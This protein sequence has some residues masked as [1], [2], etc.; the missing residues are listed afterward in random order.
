[1]S[2]HKSQNLSQIFEKKII[3]IT[4]GYFTAEKI[5]TFFDIVKK[6][7]SKF[8][9]DSGAEANLLRIIL[10]MYN[11]RAFLEEC[12]LYPHYIEILVAVSV[13][14]NYL[15]DI[16]VRDPEYFYRVVNPSNLK[17]GLIYQDFDTLICN[18]LNSYKTFNA[19]LNYLRSL[20]RRELLR[21]GLKDILGLEELPG[22]TG[23]LSVLA[24]A[25]AKNLF[26]ICFREILQKYDIKEINNSYCVISLG[27]LGGRELN[28]SS[29]IDILIFFDKNIKVTAN[30]D[31]QDFLS[32]VI[33]LFIESSTSLTGAGY[34]YRVDL[35]LRPDGKNSPL[36]NTFA[37]Y[38]NYYESRGE[39]WERQML[40]KADF[41]TGDEKLYNRFHNYIS[42][43]V[44][45]KNFS[46]SP[47][48][49]IKRMKDTIEKKLNDEE[50]I[51]LNAGGI[52]NIEFSV[53]A[54]QLLNG[55]K[56]PDIQT[57]NTLDA[58]DRLRLKNLFS[59]KESGTLKAAYIFYR[60]IEH[61]LQLMNDTQTHS[62][63]T[64]STQL[65]KLSAFL[66]F[67][68][69]KEFSR[70]L[71]KYRES[72]LRIYHSI[73]GKTGKKEKTPEIDFK[74]KIK[75]EKNILYLREGKGLLGQKQFD[76]KSAGSFL[77]IEKQLNEYLSGSSN[78]DTVVENFAR[79]IRNAKFP[80]IWYTEF[81]DKK[82][83]NSFLKL[84]EFSQKSINLFA[85]D[86]ILREIILGKKVFEKLNRNNT[87][88]LNTKALLF[89]LSV[90]ISLGMITAKKT[91][92]ILGDFVR[93]KIK[94]E[95]DEICKADHGNYLIA[96]LGSFGSAEMTFASDIDLVFITNESS[97]GGSDQ[98]IFQKLL[99]QLQKELKPFDV[100]CR[101]RPEG[102]SSQLAWNISAYEN[103]IAT[104]ART[105]EFQSFCKL[106][107]ITGNKILYNR[108]RK[109]ISSRVK[110]LD[111]LRLKTDIFEMRKKLYPTDLSG[112]VERF[113]IKKS[114]GG[115]AD[116]EFTLQYLL[117]TN[118]ASFSKFKKANNES[119]IKFLSKDLQIPLNSRVILEDFYFLKYLSFA[120]QV[121][122][123][124]N[125]SAIMFDE[126]K[127]A[128]I[129]EFLGLKDRREFH[130]KLKEVTGRNHKL[131]EKYISGNTK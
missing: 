129:S 111:R 25:I 95:F 53:Q 63:P 75:S 33:L 72:V 96:A 86:K 131:M 26:E 47:L 68:S 83:F 102:R 73:V 109:S 8:Y 79:I 124:S 128:R 41:V 32:E 44:Y 50:N 85:E 59:E 43:F 90:Q 92:G 110:E 27:K 18:D 112:L 11:K 84:C 123:D 2:P 38:T 6:E 77:K 94:D 108:L 120:S 78:P 12:I 71:I 51:K 46:V 103:Y 115:L 62:V 88:T 52:R 81:S 107:Y 17:Q 57:P 31:Y 125:T 119:V 21:I 118:P 130:K 10:G 16:L 34:I 5:D 87:G 14:S 101:L 40:I 74:D 67:S 97:P 42:H 121:L 3:E 106:D 48:E 113:D 91:S 70:E 114:R 9:F 56:F 29:D 58:I 64:N 61:Y 55:G 36:C 23:E 37:S 82:F 126:I 116:I 54:L 60:K 99:L 39:D 122:F 80:S 4:A 1:M 127:T 49:Q 66:G 69:E 98:K 20:K 76:K 105:W 65:K 22:L 19:R 35:R 28:Y 117:L 89:Y 7:I 24:K 45:P 100:D 15:T 93:E 13:N 30:K 104:R